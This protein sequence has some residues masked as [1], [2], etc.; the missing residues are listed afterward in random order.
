[1]RSGPD[2]RKS[3]VAR[4]PA[5]MY[6]G[7]I[8]CSTR[9]DRCGHQRCSRASIRSPTIR[10]ATAGPS[11]AR[12]SARIRST[13]RNRTWC[14]YR[15]RWQHEAVRSMNSAIVAASPGGER[16]AFFI[17]VRCAPD[18]RVGA[19]HSC[20][21]RKCWNSRGPGTPTSL[22]W[23]R[24]RGWTEHSDCR[25]RRYAAGHRDPRRIWLE[26]TDDP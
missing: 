11:T 3:S 6:T 2:G 20:P 5:R 16:S 4:W 21:L 23:T 18:G 22:Q 25:K 13:T 19:T 26:T 8:P 17:G 14:R 1:M 15:R 10:R 9:A 7:E 12:P 24:F